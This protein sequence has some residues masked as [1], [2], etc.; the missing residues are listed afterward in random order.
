MDER[1]KTSYI[2]PALEIV[3]VEIEK[4]IATSQ[5]EIGESKEEG[6]TDANGHRGAWGN[7][8]D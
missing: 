2:K 3:D 5:I 1:M 7:L 8:W 4:M 6:T